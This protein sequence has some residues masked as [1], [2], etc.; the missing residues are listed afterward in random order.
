MIYEDIYKK[1]EK[2]EE[3]S[4]LSDLIDELRILSVNEKS[5]KMRSLIN[6]TLDSSRVFNDKISMVKLYDLKIR[7][8]YSHP[9]NL[10]EIES[11]LEEMKQISSE[12]DCLEGNALVNLLSWYIEKLKET[13]KKV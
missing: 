5:D 12:I 7:Q 9:R 1:I 13:P 2:I 10:S 4:E 6:K 3:I 11:I 8:L